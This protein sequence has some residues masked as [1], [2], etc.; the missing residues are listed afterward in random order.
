MDPGNGT[1]L[2]A[3]K[4]SQHHAALNVNIY[5]SNFVLNSPAANLCCE[6]VDSVPKINYPLNMLSRFLTLQNITLHTRILWFKI[7]FLFPPIL[8][9][10]TL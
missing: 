8:F 3:A 7:S 10:S 9:L 2:G 1:S 4:P 6:T 5:S